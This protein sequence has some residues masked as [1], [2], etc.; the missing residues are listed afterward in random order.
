MKKLGSSIVTAASLTGALVLVAPTQAA[1][2]TDEI[3]V[4]N[5]GIAAV[6]QFTIQQHLNYVA[7]GSKDPAFPGLFP[8]NHSLNGTPEFAYGVTDWWEVGLYLPF[9]VQTSSFFQ[10]GSSCARCDGIPSIDGWHL[11]AEWCRH[12][13]VDASVRVCARAQNILTRS[14]MLIALPC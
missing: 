3:Q 4:Y 9:S 7:L 14:R 5:A 12:Q 11:L 6:G 2:A 8:S 13:F 10:T 1:R